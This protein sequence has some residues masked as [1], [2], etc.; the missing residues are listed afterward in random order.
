MTNSSASRALF[1]VA[2]ERARQIAKG[3]TPERDDNYKDQELIR[4]TTCILGVST[5]KMRG[6]MDVKRTL[7]LL[8]PHLYPFHETGEHLSLDDAK[9]AHLEKMV[10]DPRDAL[11]RAAALILAEIERIDRAAMNAST[12]TDED[13]SDDDELFPLSWTD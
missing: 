3:H 11:V 12:A 1:D 2:E 8:A 4:A 13:F 6:N 7:N 10:A 9:R 5:A